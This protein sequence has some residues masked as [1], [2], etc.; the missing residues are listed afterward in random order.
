MDQ[1]RKRGLSAN[2][3][4][5]Y[6]RDLA[7]WSAYCGSVGV[8]A[9]DATT[10]DVAAFV[11]ALGAGDPP[12]RKPMAPASVARILVAVRS[13]YRMLVSE[14]TVGVDPTVGVGAPRAASAGFETVAAEEVDRLLASARRGSL[15]LR[16][17]ALLALLYGAGLRISEAVGLDIRDADL[18]RGRVLVRGGRKQ[19]FVPLGERAQRDVGTFMREGRA[20]LGAVGE[21][22]PLLVN[23]RGGR[24]S[25]QGCWKILKGYAHAAGI[26]TKVSPH[27]LRHSFAAHMLEAGEDLKT[28]QEW[29][30]H[31]S[32]TTTQIYAGRTRGTDGS[33]SV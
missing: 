16:D 13:L 8:A 14:G 4:G 27:T 29:L 22:L 12:A 31:A 7:I 30:G 6:Q 19:R 21:D 5:A 20:K 9:L 32:P 3:L 2:T 28:V 15:G 18:R 25:R 23:S 24:L 1:A 26:G 10:G 17:R 33:S 11:R